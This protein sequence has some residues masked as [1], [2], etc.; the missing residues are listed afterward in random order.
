MIKDINYSGYSAVPDDYQAPDGDLSLSL[1]LINEDGAL[2]GI[3]APEHIM[4]IAQGHEVLLIHS[5]PQQDNIIVLSGNRSR[6][7]SLLWLKKDESALST[8]QAVEIHDSDLNTLLS[9]VPVGNT[10]AVATTSGVFYILWKDSTYKFL[11]SKPPF[12]PIRFGAFK[13]NDLTKS[14]STIY[15]D[16]PAA[17]YTRY[18]STGGG[19]S[20]PRGENWSDADDN[21]WNEVSNQS[22]GLLLS[23]VNDKVTAHGYV[24]QPFFLRY[25]YKLYDGSYSWHSAPIL[26]LVNIIRPEIKISCAAADGDS[27]MKITCQLDVPYFSV[28]YKILGDLPLLKEWD[29]IITGI[30]VFF[31]APIYTYDQGAKMAEPVLRS[32]FYR[33]TF[34]GYGGKDSGRNSHFGTAP[35]ESGNSDAELDKDSAG[36]AFIGH[37]CHSQ[38][39]GTGKPDGLY[40]DHVMKDYSSL[41]DLVCDLRP[42][43]RF[44]D[45]IQTESIFYKVC[46]LSLDE[47]ELKEEMRQLPIEKCDLANITTLPTLPDDFNSHAIICPESLHSYNQRLLMSGLSIKPAIPFPFSS[48]AQ[49]ADVVSTAEEALQP[50]EVRV[51]TRVNGVK[52]VSKYQLSGGSGAPVPYPFNDSF[53]RYIFHPDPS[54]YQMEIRSVSGKLFTLPLKQHPFLNGSYW[55]G[56]LGVEPTNVWENTDDTTNESANISNRIYVSEVNN[57]FC[58]PAQYAVSIGCQHVYGVSSAAKALSQGQFGQFPLYAFT[59]EGVWALEISSTGVISARQPITRDV[60]INPQG[61]TQIDSAV[62]FPTDRGIMLISGSQTQCISESINSEFPFNPLSLPGFRKL[63]SM[64]HPSE[65]SC[66]PLIPFTRFLK[67]CAMV[68]DYSHQRIIVYNKDFSYS[69]VFSLK[70]QLWGMMFSDILYGVKSYPDALAVSSGN[71][72][73]DFAASHLAE[74]GNPDP[75][76]VGALFLTRPLKLDAADVLKTIDTIIQ[77]GNFRKDHV[78]SVLYGSRD[79]YNWHLVW[80]SKDHYLRGFRGTPYKYFRIALLCSLSEDESIFGASLQ[81]TPR[82]TNQPR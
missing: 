34:Y 36:D 71:G 41:N 78:Q 24:Y 76:P 72:L 75:A 48:Y 58:F 81:F 8:S 12:L 63:H 39:A 67:G 2:K 38:L 49:A 65:D 10:L 7:F 19:A 25:A 79:L 53:P 62:L 44:N 56:G 30:D 23:E 74:D 32:S 15:S 50:E 47:L 61:I 55:F 3:P 28:A 18:T 33:N 6:A 60:C 9:I 40:V 4:D 54:A 35:S 51:F 80:S 1:N 70:S 68:Y 66:F 52:C 17:T 26:I 77:R 42:N 45:K 64:L 29:D 11:G 82:Q 69:Y 5:V 31:T 22:L 57:P 46:S 27:S 37:Y 14:S 16:V 43:A 21:F 20:H 59:D 13:V 73:V